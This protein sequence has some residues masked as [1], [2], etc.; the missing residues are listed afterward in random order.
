MRRLRRDLVRSPREPGI[1]I[2][3]WGRSA[4]GSVREE[5][6]EVESF[7]SVWKGR[8]VTVDH[9]RKRGRLGKKVPKNV[10]GGGARRATETN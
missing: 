2:W 9:V 10:S 5:G 3:S 7:F 6:S 4:D 1:L 8:I